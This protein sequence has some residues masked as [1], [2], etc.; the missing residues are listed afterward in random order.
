MEEKTIKSPDISVITK[1]HVNKW[2]VLTSDYK[3]LIAVGDSLSSVLEKAKQPDKV[4][5]K[6]LPELGYAPF[7]R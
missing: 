7:L 4:V 3:K 1:Q 2:V 5:M 6:V